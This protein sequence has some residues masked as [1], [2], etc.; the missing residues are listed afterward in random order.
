MFGLKLPS[1]LKKGAAEIEH[2]IKKERG[3]I[4]EV[5]EQGSHLAW[6]RN[7]GGPVW[8]V[9]GPPPDQDGKAEAGSD[10]AAAATTKKGWG[11]VEQVKAVSIAEALAQAEAAEAAHAMAQHHGQHHASQQQGSHTWQGR[12]G[13]G[14]ARG[15]PPQPPQPLPVVTSA[16]TFKEPVFAGAA[17]ADEVEDEDNSLEGLDIPVAE[18]PAASLAAPPKDAA[19]EVAKQGGADVPSGPSSMQSTPSPSNWREQSSQS[20]EAASSAG[21]G[22]GRG[23]VGGAVGGGPAPR[24]ATPGH[25]HQQ[26][27]PPMMGRSNAMERQRDGLRPSEYGGGG[28]YGNHS[29]GEDYAGRREAEERGGLQRGGYERGG[30]D[31]GYDRGFGP[32][33][34]GGSMDRVAPTWGSRGDSSHHGHRDEHFGGGFGD[35]YNSDRGGYGGGYGGG[36]YGGR[37]Q[38]GGGGGGYGRVEGGYNR[39]T[40]GGYNNHNHNHNHNNMGNNNN[41]ADWRDVDAQRDRSM[42]LPEAPRDLGRHSATGTT[43][44]RPPSG[45]HPNHHPTNGSSAYYSKSPP[46]RFAIHTSPRADLIRGGLRL[47]VDL[48][49]PRGDGCTHAHGLIG[50][51]QHK[52]FEGDA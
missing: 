17:W 22:A 31:R 44:Y 51:F 48:K 13:G 27:Q 39:G 50:V 28:G 34:N 38:Y 9:Q 33:H 26:Q 36:G 3:E 21:G 52:G 18:A 8:G 43:S 19:A 24:G 2:T 10:T 14:M 35:R 7:K 40:H 29:H 45:G 30:F 6:K 46:H 23:T 32:Q 41:G 5:V 37:G 42:S 11:S 15:G 12:Y 1:Q 16:E 25:Q 49:Q 20:G 47:T 4:G